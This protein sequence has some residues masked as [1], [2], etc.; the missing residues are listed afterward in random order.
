MPLAPVL[1]PVAMKKK[2][3]I[4]KHVQYLRNYLFG[5]MRLGSAGFN[6]ARDFQSMKR[7]GKDSHRGQ[8]AN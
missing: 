4:K 6:L 2:E 8:R 3:R 1:G 5:I 7:G